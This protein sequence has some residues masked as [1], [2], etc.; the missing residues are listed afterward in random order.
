MTREDIVAFK[1]EDGQRV[2][3]FL[4]RNPIC[5]AYLLG[6][7]DPPYVEHTTWL[8]SSWDEQMI[9]VILSYAGL[10]SPVVLSSGAPDGVAQIVA[11]YVQELP[12]EAYAKVP[13]EH[14]DAW[15]PHFHLNEVQREWIMGLDVERF[16]PIATDNDIRRLRSGHPLS[17]FDGLYK[18]YPGHFFEPSQLERG[19]YYGVFVDGTLVGVSGTHVFSPSTG[20]AVLGNIVTAAPNRGQGLATDCTSAVLQEVLAQGCRHVALQVSATNAPAIAVYRRLGFRY[21]GD[22]LQ[23]R[24]VRTRGGKKRRS[25]N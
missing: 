4:K 5:A 23:A 6:D 2:R 19:V 8:A 3:D 24:V 15:T 25:C 17:H 1:E 14:R 20:V 22:V 10:S 12:A 13:V 11:Q 18:H 7:L 21:H 9:A 16:R